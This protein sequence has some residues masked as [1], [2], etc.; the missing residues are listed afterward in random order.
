MSILKVKCAVTAACIPAAGAP[1]QATYF[2][3]RAVNAGMT[4]LASDEHPVSEA[5]NGFITMTLNMPA[6]PDD[7]TIYGQGADSDHAFVGEQTAVA[8]VE[9]LFFGP[10]VPA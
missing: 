3:A 1:A 9:R 2:S 6:N 4:V 8:Y 10:A 5:V 7:F